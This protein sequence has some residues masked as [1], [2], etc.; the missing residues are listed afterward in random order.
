M[1]PEIRL[2]LLYFLFGAL[3][4]FASDSIVFGIVGEQVE[5]SRAASTIKGVVFVLTTTLLLYGVMRRELR[6]QDEAA[7]KILSTRR[8]F[9]YLFKK[10]PHPMWV[11]DLQTLAFV[12]VNNAAIVHL[13]YLR[14]E[15]LAMTIKDVRPAEDMPRLLEAVSQLRP[16]YNQFGEWRLRTKDRTIID[17]EIFTH[18]LQFEGREAALAVAVDITDRKR[19]ERALRE[20][21][22]RLD[23]ILANLTDAVWAVDAR[24]DRLVYLNPAIESLSRRSLRELFSSRAVRREMVHP[25]D[26]DFFDE[27]AHYLIA[28]GQRSIEYRI[29]RPD[30]VV[31]WVNDRSWTVHDDSG[32]LIRYDGILTDITDR[33]QIQAEMLENERLRVALENEIELRRMR[34]RFASMVSHEFRNPLAAISSSVSMLEHYFI[35]MSEAQ[36]VERFGNIYNQVNQLTALLDDMLLMMKNDMVTPQF[37]TQPVDLAALCDDIVEQ[38]RLVDNEGHLILYRASAADALIEGDPKLLRQALANLI[39]NAIK[40]SPAATRID[41]ELSRSEQAYLISVRDQG[42]GIPADELDAVFEPF[43]RANNT[44]EIK[45]TGLGLAITRQ[46]IQLHGGHIKVE[47][48]VG[49]GSRFT[50]HLPLQPA[51]S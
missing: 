51:S 49:A 35:R 42:M 21:E 31:R 2:S 43:R 45:G 38:M 12:E 36:R 4:I 6:K 25:D 41:I 14:D 10:N 40:Y 32:V 47:S 48:A 17:V 20:S 18:R 30:G 5:Q 37:N 23:S 19:A 13:G 39:A 34:D 29:L 28:R 26:R 24:D 46:A 44:G 33:K 50:I 15:F 22:A 27:Q 9:E 7:Q 8:D 3:W 1:K 16:E 11:Y